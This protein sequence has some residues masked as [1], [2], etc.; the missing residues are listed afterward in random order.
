MRFGYLVALLLL[1]M[2][3][4]LTCSFPFNG[5][6][7]L[8]VYIPHINLMRN[9]LTKNT[10][11]VMFVSD[12]TLQTTLKTEVSQNKSKKIRG[13]NP[14]IDKLLWCNY[15]R[16][17]YI[18]SRTATNAVNGTTAATMLD[19]LDIVELEVAVASPS[20][21]LAGMERPQASARLPT[22]PSSKARS[23]TVS[24]LASNNGSMSSEQQPK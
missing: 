19:S 1:L 4:I 13:K 5:K 3:M 2:F 12:S 9:I 16:Q 24:E 7:I 8:N 6:I 21:Q 23:R 11:N 20:G 10:V 22:G 15:N 14:K 17:K 18:I